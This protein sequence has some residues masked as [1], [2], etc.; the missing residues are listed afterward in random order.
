MNIP[1]ARSPTLAASLLT[2][3]TIGHLFGDDVGADR[4][5][6]VDEAPM[7]A[8]AMRGE[9]A[10]AGRFALPGR[11]VPLAVFPG[12]APLA[13]LFDA[14]TLVVVVRVVGAA[15]AVHLAL[16]SADGLCVGGQL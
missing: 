1:G 15:L 16:E 2:P 12:E 8:L 3:R 14:P 10:L 11:Q 7:Q 9:S 6:L 5:D 4:H 13:A